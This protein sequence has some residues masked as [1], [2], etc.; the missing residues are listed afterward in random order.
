VCGAALVPVMAILIIYPF[1]NKS[2]NIYIKEKKKKKRGLRCLKPHR[3]D[4]VAAVGYQ[5]GNIR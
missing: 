4:V 3:V 1:S 5:S 2:Y